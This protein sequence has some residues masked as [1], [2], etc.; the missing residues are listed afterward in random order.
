MAARRKKSGEAPELFIEQ[1]GQLRM[2][3]KSAEQQALEKR[4]V[5]CLG[6][7]FDSE[8]ARRAY[9]LDK[10]REKLKDPEFRK[11][12]GF[13][14]GKDEDILAL[15]DPPYYTAC[16]NP[17]LADFVRCYG[18]PYDPNTRYSRT[19]FAVDV[20]EGKTDPLYTAHSYHT[21]VPHKA[22]MRAI[23]HYTEPGDVVLD[24]F[25]GSG[26]T[27][28]A[29]QM[30]E[31]PDPEFRQQIEG[32]WKQAGF[33]P[34]RWGARRA[35]L[36]ELAPAATFIAANY[37]IPFDVDAFGQAAK[38]ILDE[39]EAELGWMYETFHKDKK[40][41]GRIK[42][43]VWSEVFSCPECSKE[44][45]FLEEAL[46]S[47][48]KRVREDFPCPHCGVKLTKDNLQR[49]FETLRDPATGNPWKRIRLRPVL[50]N[51]SVRKENFEKRPDSKDLAILDRIEKLPLP[52]EVP[53]DLFPIESMYHGSRLAPKGFTHVHHLFLPRPAQSLARLWRKAR[54]TL[55][56]RLRSAM[57][58][59]AEQAIWGMSVLARY[60][61]TH[62]SQ[63]NQY[64][65]GVYYIGSQI[66]D[67]NPEY[68]LGGKLR[69]LVKAFC[70]YPTRSLF[71]CTA[72]TSSTVSLGIPS[73]C[74]DYVFTDPPFGSNIPYADLNFI[75]ESWHMVRTDA[76]PEAIVD[77]AKDKA[78]PQ[79]QELMRRCLV[80]FYR[81]LKPGRWM[82]MV[83][84]N[85]SNAV[86]NAI[87]EAI[88]SAGFVVADVRTLD[89]QQGSYRQVTST[90]VKQD[91]VISAY[92]PNCGL[93]QRFV[94]EA[95]TEE[96]VWYF[97]RAHLKQLPVFVPKD[98]LAEVIAER[99][100]YLLFDRMVAFHV[101]RGV[102]VPVSAAEFNA[103]LA[104]R[105]IP[106]DGMYFLPEQAA[107]YDRKRM[108]VKAVAQLELFVIDESTAIQWL[109]QELGNKPYTLQELTPRFMQE[110][111]RAW[112]KHEKP[113]E[114]A[115]MLSQNFLCYDG[116][117]EVPSQIHSYLSTNFKDLR[118]LA[119]DNP[120]LCAKAKDRW[121]VPDP[122]KAG[123]LE[124]LRERT[125]LREFD[126]Y[127]ESTQKQLKVFRLEAVRAG[128]KRAWQDR[129][130][131]T[132]IAVARKIPENVL[133]E[134][135]KLLMWYDQALTRSGVEA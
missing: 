51:Y 126:E 44:V 98:G 69:R 108:T 73:D 28:V 70:E 122:N 81:V 85:S 32:E 109:R 45:V 55:D 128:F 47:S 102:T 104:Q 90:A 116:D 130:Y 86:W 105:F 93:E 37:N 67:V 18:K 30:C 97:V 59:F 4:R 22:I 74:V 11:I 5:E 119:K 50:I 88:L 115:E 26:M 8:E 14:I 111:Q 76:R 101:Q 6:M 35:V 75:I 80:E 133:Q 113:L 58:F 89:K 48:T 42:Y 106:R 114:L 63:V 135:P 9:F 92:K 16:P 31:R 34:P 94:A 87:Q 10:L 131:A 79:Y 107:E 91:L 21:K 3:D 12:E 61:P 1:T 46:D 54:S 127:R 129:E 2:T 56:S 68:I 84:H 20:S 95:G 123:D 52:P 99:Q 110:A 7:V 118:N 103:G 112:A 13:P 96:G 65:S 82:T 100:A 17:F 124:K 19:P 40:T 49:N 27:G 120:L 36:G 66:V 25:A 62:Y 53:T 78:L 125:L 72:T 117:G 38:R 121:Y 43:T 33:D 64:L 23:L 41:K 83:F 134:D 29:A 39:V 71:G 60:A 57:L 77:E 24:G 15:S 132:I